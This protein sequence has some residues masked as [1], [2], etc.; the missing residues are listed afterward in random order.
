VRSGGIALCI[1]ILVLVSCGYFDPLNPYNRK[2]V[3]SSV[4][5]ERHFGGTGEDVARSVQQTSDGGYV[6]TGYTNSSGA[7]GY[8]LWLVKVKANSKGDVEWSKTFGGAGDEYGYSGQQTADGGYILVG[9]TMSSGA[10]G[11]DVYLIK[12]YA[13]GDL[14]WYQSF[15]GNMDDCGYSVQCT[16]D[17]GY[18]ITGDTFSFGAGR[19]DVY[20]IKTDSSGAMLW[21]KTFGDSTHQEQGF[22]LRLTKDP[23]YVIAGMIT[24]L[25]NPE[26][27]DEDAYLVKTDADGNNPLSKVLGYKGFHDG[28]TAVQPIEGGY[29]LCGYTEVGQGDFNAWLINTDASLDLQV[30]WIFGGGSWDQA[31][32]VQQTPDAGYIISGMTKSWGPPT[33]GPYGQAWLL[34]TDSSGKQEWSK[35]FG[36]DGDEWGL[37]VQQTADGGYIMAGKTSSFS[38]AGDMDAYLIYYKP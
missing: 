30:N 29:I 10:G 31:Q 20:L 36:G 17:G 22:C 23:G 6:L 16:S 1:L 35:D 19:G 3:D 27:L 12:T 26:E 7:G 28:G 4:T 8:D 24:D 33:S 5:W 11:Y 34:K 14:D 32:A 18:I 25:S 21:S 2:P 13:D 37:C 38:L 9:S 15:G